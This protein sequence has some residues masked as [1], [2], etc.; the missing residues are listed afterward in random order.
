M[1]E[2]HEERVAASPTRHEQLQPN[3][4]NNPCWLGV[5]VGWPSP[6]QIS[7]GRHGRRHDGRRLRLRFAASAR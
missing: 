1:C 2:R 6:V 7:E 4:V 5:A 3:G